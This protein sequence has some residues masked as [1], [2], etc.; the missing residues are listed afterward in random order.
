MPLPELLDELFRLYRRHFSLIV[1]VALIVALPGAAGSLLPIAWL[2]RAVR[3]HRYRLD[4]RF[5]HWL[6]AAGA[7]RP[8][9]YRCRAVLWRPLV[10]VGRKHDGGGCRAHSRPGPQLGPGQEPV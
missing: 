3:R 1:V 4:D 6:R 10:A 8:R 7:A 9:G 2:G 5:G